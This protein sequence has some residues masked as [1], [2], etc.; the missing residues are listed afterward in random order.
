VV[1]Q[2]IGTAASRV[3]RRLSVTCLLLH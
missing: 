2:R 3:N 1:Q